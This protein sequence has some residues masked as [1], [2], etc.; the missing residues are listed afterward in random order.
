MPVS[1]RDNVNGEFR[2]WRVSRYPH[3]VAEPR[4]R[5]E[6]FQAAHPEVQFVRVP[7]AGRMTWMFRTRDNLEIFKKWVSVVRQ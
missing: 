7:I 2:T 5:P 4:G 1:R 6:D 3:E